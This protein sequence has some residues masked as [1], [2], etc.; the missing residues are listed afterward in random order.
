M[1]VGG[2]LLKQIKVSLEKSGLLTH[3]SQ[4]LAEVGTQ[5]IPLVQGQLWALTGA[6]AALA[7]SAQGVETAQER[8]LMVT[9]ITVE[10]KFRPKVIVIPHPRSHLAINVWGHLGLLRGRLA[11]PLACLLEK[12][13]KGF[14][15]QPL[16]RYSPGLYP[17][18]SN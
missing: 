18:R 1:E 10:P 17:I 3:Q 2:Q 8:G 15:L 12:T 7:P 16:P 5:L 9:E 13:G 14:T 4:E 11:N 6:V